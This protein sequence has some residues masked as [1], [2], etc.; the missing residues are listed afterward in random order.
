[1]GL[2]DIFRRRKK[3]KADPGVGAVLDLDPETAERE[4]PETRFTEEYR[5]FLA[6]REEEE[7]E[8]QEGE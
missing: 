5:E 2:W 7:G 1:M 4:A 8:E 6:R 3:K